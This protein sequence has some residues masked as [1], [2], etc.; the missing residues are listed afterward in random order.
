MKKSVMGL[1]CAALM[2]AGTAYAATSIVNVPISQIVTA[3]DDQVT[4]M[5]GTIG[6]AVVVNGVGTYNY[7]DATGNPATLTV[8]SPLKSGEPCNSTLMGWARG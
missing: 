5:S 8:H 3:F 6:T 7:T 4:G 2:W 1:A